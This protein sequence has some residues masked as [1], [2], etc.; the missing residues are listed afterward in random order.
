MPKTHPLGQNGFMLKDHL[1][2]GS[3]FS[4]EIKPDAASIYL[5]KAK[6]NK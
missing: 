1:L 3:K 4:E 2:P 6:L 5:F